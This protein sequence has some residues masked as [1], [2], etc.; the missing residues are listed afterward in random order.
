MCPRFGPW[1]EVAV[2]VE[3]D[4]DRGVSHEGLQRLEV[5]ARGDHQA[6]ED[7]P[8]LV[9]GDRGEPG[10]VPVP[11]GAVADRRGSKGS[12]GVRPKTSAEE[13]AAERE[14]RCSRRTVATGTTR[15]P[16]R[17]FGSITPTTRSQLRSTRMT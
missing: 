6:R 10:R 1:E 11:V 16:A 3:R 9:H 13:A 14:A 17:D 5:H 7:V 12:S 15:W 8:A 4:G 2:A